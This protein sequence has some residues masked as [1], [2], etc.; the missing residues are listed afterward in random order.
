MKFCTL[1]HSVPRLG[2]VFLLLV[3]VLAFLSLIGNLYFM[4][5]LR[6]KCVKAPWLGNVS[7]DIYQDEF[8]Y[9]TFINTPGTSCL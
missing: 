4:G 2:P 3:L 7:D 5:S 1:I 9:E 8:E 6:N